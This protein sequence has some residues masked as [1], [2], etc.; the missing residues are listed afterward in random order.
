MPFGVFPDDLSE[1]YPI[2]QSEVISELE[3][4]GRDATLDNIISFVKNHPEAT[5]T[6]AYDAIWECPMI[7]EVGKVAMLVKLE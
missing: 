7:A 6:F 2:G 4:E 1:T 3:C 5:F